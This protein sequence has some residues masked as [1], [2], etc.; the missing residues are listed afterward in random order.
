MKAL[1]AYVGADL[2]AW[3]EWDAVSLIATA[4][5]RLPLLIDQGEADEFLAPQ[6]RPE[7]LEQA[8]RAAG[9]PA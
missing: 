2:E 8:C 9:H 4:R 1:T 6:L 3:A 5:E 7:L